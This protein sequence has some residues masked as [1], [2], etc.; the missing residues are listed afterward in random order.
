[1]NYLDEIRAKDETVCTSN[2]TNLGELKDLI[3]ESYGKTF[4]DNYCKSLPEELINN[5]TVVFDIRHKLFSYIEDIVEYQ[6]L[7]YK[8]CYVLEKDLLDKLKNEGY[9]FTHQLIEESNGQS[10]Y[11]LVV[12]KKKSTKL[13]NDFLF[14]I[15][16]LWSITLGLN[17]ARLPLFED[18][19]YED[20]GIRCTSYYNI[21][22]D[23]EEDD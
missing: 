13:W 10:Y 19:L 2:N 5:D 8:A 3:Y 7:N 12:C 4:I 14:D 16:E 11:V 9:L 17:T 22:S 21:K 15:D 20:S 18:K 6:E 23:S 1:M